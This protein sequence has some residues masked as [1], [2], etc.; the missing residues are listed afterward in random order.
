MDH[1]ISMYIDNELS[2]GEKILFVEHAATA[3]SAE[4][5]P[6]EY[7]NTTRPRFPR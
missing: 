6:P 2:L 1:L 5:T 4:S 3:R 7:P